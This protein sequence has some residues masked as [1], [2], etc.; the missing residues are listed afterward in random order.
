MCFCEIFAEPP[1]HFISTRNNA[2]AVTLSQAIAAGLAPDGGLYVPQQMPASRTL[3]AGASLAETAAMLLQPF[4]ADDAL[5]AELPRIC[6]DAFDFPAP[7]QPLA[8]GNDHVLELFHGPTAA[9]KDFGARF[10]AASLSRLRARQER[11][12]T[13]VVATSGDTGA[14][15][16]APSTTSRT[17]KWWCCTRMAAC[18]R[19]R[20]T[21]WGAWAAISAHCAWPA[22]SMIAR[23]WPSRP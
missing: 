20:R 12:L 4:F 14:A 15:V 6:V 1:M 11:P 13:I 21:S 7:L 9:F 17:C 22:R 8:T 19:G 16:A 10:L 5:Q 23:A 18:R 2:P 3:Q